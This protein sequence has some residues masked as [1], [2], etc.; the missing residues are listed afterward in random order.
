[1]KKV[2]AVLL[3]ALTLVACTPK[4][5]HVEQQTEQQNLIVRCTTDTPIPERNGIDVNGKPA[6]TGADM[7]RALLLWQDVYNECAGTHDKLVDSILGQKEA[8]KK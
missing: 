7:M 4:V 2:I 5:V 1:M 6:S 3:I 8:A